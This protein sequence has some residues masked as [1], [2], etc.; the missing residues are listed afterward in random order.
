MNS[1]LGSPAEGSMYFHRPQLDLEF[2][3][4]LDIHKNLSIVA[5]RRVG[6]TSFMLHITKN[7]SKNFRAIYTIT[8][9]VNVSNAFFKKIYTSIY[10]YLEKNKKAKEYLKIKSKTLLVKKISLSVTGGFSID[11]DRIDIDFYNEM[12]ELVRDVKL[13]DQSIILF[14]DE[15]AQTVEN[16][17]KDQGIEE[18]ATF[19]HQCREIRAHVNREHRIHFVYA[20]SIGLE[21]LVSSINESRTINDIGSFIIPALSSLEAKHLNQ[22]I[23][24]G[25]PLK[26]GDQV[27]DYMLDKLG[28]L[29]P[30][31]IHLI[32]SEIDVLRQKQKFETINREHIDQAFLN[33]LQH[34]NYFDHWFTR[35]RSNLSGNKFSFAKDILEL[36]AREKS[37]NIYQIGDLADKHKLEFPKEILNILIHDGYISKTDGMYTFTSPLLRDWWLENIVL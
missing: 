17:I 1:I 10:E 29:I 13:E 15:F 19:L 20:G 12:I 11:F 37:I 23:L 2:Y 32:L 33:A 14:I 3:R 18:A 24:D 7:S 30:H 36:A 16:I 5:A 8:E 4:L 21:N 9:S 22:Q 34:R 28:Y 25:D 26:F 6:K 27:E 31:Y 35:L